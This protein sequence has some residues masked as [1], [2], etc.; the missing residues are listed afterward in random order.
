MTPPSYPLAHGNAGKLARAT[1]PSADRF[2]RDAGALAN[3]EVLGTE[4]DHEPT[5][6]WRRSL[7]AAREPID[8]GPAPAT[9]RLPLGLHR[10]PVPPAPPAKKVRVRIDEKGLIVVRYEPTN[11][12]SIDDDNRS[13]R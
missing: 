2:E 5:C 10:A 7:V 11:I 4:D 13:E 1:S 6:L 3:G 9:E 12:G 8:Q